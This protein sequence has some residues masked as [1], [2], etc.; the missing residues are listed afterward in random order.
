MMGEGLREVALSSRRGPDLSKS[1]PMASRWLQEVR[2]DLHW[3]NSKK[4]V[5]LRQVCRIPNSKATVLVLPLLMM[6]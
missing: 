1:L 2:F 6:N 5:G 3:S 4:A